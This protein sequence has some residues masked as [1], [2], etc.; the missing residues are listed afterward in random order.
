MGEQFCKK[1]D[2]SK[3]VGPICKQQLMETDTYKSMEARNE[4]KKSIHKVLELIIN[5]ISKGCKR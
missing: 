4:I 1:Y 2:I 5:Y 3:Y